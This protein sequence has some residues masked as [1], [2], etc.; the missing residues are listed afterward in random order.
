MASTNVRGKMASGARRG[1]DPQR[2][3]CGMRPGY[4]G[5][6]AMFAAASPPAATAAAAARA[7]AL[8][9]RVIAVIRRGA[10]G[11]STA[12][13][14]FAAQ[15]GGEHR[16]SAPVLPPP[17]QPPQQRHAK[18]Q[19]GQVITGGQDGVILRARGGQ[20]LSAREFWGAYSGRSA[21]A[22]ACGKSRPR[23]CR[24]AAWPTR[25]LPTR[26]AACPRLAFARRTPKAAPIS[27]EGRHAPASAASRASSRGPAVHHRRNPSGRQGEDQNSS[28]R[29][30]LFE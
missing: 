7:S 22:W 15:I 20:S 14:Q 29:A 12:G 30:V 17:P 23:A 11:P 5:S 13:K 8:R 16:V 19:S 21:T 3:Q 10:I 28:I 27:Q 2:F 24:K 4:A 9:R 25:D 1:A 6:E 26:A 18:A